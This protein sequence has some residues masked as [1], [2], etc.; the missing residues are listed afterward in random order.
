MTL[1]MDQPKQLQ[2]LALCGGYRGCL[3][4]K[5]MIPSEESPKEA[6]ELQTS[7]MSQVFLKMFSKT[8]F[9]N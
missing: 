6:K 3:S 2:I 9:K 8:F 7:P 5:L 4:A 1:V